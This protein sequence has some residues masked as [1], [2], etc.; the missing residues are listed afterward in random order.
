MG[1]DRSS[2]PHDVLARTEGRWEGT[3]R[4]W[5]EPGKLADT[6]P[7]RGTV[8]LVLDGAFALHEY[9]GSLSGQAMK[10]LAIHGYAK[11]ERRFETAW[12]DSC[13]NGTRIMVSLG[14]ASAWSGGDAASVFGTYPAPEGPDWGWRTEVDVAQTPERLVIRHFNVTPDGEEALA[15]EID[16]HRVA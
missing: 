10:G 2:R 4:T 9:E 6:S 13:H 11:G 3:A 16:Y 5:F 14:E 15:V 1:D 12:I 8:R 7:I